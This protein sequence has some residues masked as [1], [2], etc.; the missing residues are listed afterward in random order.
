MR[1]ETI[2]FKHRAIYLLLLL[3]AV[4]AASAQERGRAVKIPKDAVSCNEYAPAMKQIFGQAV[5][6]LLSG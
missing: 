4:T 6:Q 1:G 5:R 2:M 3:V